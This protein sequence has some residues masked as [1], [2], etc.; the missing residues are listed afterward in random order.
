MDKMREEFDV[1]MENPHWSWAAGDR[2]EELYELWKASRA[3]L[4]VELPKTP[5]FSASDEPDLAFEYGVE[6]MKDL[7]ESAGITCK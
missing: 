7:I 2:K 6:V 1:F 3:S 4:C 5:D